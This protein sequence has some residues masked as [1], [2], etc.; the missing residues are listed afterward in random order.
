MMMWFLWQHYFFS[1]CLPATACIYSGPSPVDLACPRNHLLHACRYRYCGYH[2]QDTAAGRD[3]THYSFWSMRAVVYGF[4]INAASWLVCDTFLVIFCIFHVARI[5]PGIFVFFT[6]TRLIRMYSSYVAWSKTR[7]RYAVWSLVLLLVTGVRADPKCS[8]PYIWYF[9]YVRED[10]H[11]R[12]FIKIFHFFSRY[13]V[14]GSQY[15]FLFGFNNIRRNTCRSQ[16]VRYK[17]KTWKQSCVILRR[18]R[19]D[20]VRQVARMNDCYGYTIVNCVWP[21]YSGMSQLD[22][23]FCDKLTADAGWWRICVYVGQ[24]KIYVLLW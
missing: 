22:G 7:V 18:Q 21:Q 11:F 15:D 13:L 17:A 6:H 5:I 9:M 19:D 23:V 1:G 16:F 24:I 10:C 8:Y 12:Y 14:V 2:P 4:S 3:R 20:A